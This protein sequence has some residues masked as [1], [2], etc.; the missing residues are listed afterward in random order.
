MSG[1]VCVTAI[2]HR[3]YPTFHAAWAM[4]CFGQHILEENQTMK[5]KTIQ[6]CANAENQVYR[7]QLWE[8]RGLCM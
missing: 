7:Q 5:K 6:V 2:I 8:H 1:T 4:W 3:M